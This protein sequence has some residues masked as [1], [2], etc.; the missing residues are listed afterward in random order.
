V[1]LLTRTMAILV[2]AF[3]LTAVAAFPP[4]A[5]GVPS[6]PEI[7]AKQAEGVAAQDQLDE[8]QAQLELRAEEYGAI[9]LELQGTR[10]EIA[11]TRA[12]LEKA[13]AELAR[14]LEQLEQRAA[15]IYRNGNVEI[16]D[17]LLGTTS[18]QDFLTRVDW[19]RRVNLSDAEIAAAVKTARQR[20]IETEEALERREQEQITLRD[21]AA[22]KKKEIEGAVAEQAAFLEGLNT[23]IAR[24]VEDERKRQEELAAERARQAAEAARRA[25]EAVGWSAG[26]PIA[27][28]VGSLGAGHPEALAAGLQYVGVPYV[29]GGA[30]PEGFDCSGLTQYAYA[31]VGISLPRTSREQFRAGQYIPADR[32]DLLVTGDLVFFGYGG[33]PNRIHHVGIY[34]GEGGFLHAPQTGSTV[35]VSSLL[36]RISSR[37]D[38]VGACRP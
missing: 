11:E 32:L 2:A 26:A 15:G 12:A 8:L 23:E 22:V 27:A 29:W 7:Q 30:S 5:A 1:S 3:A 9:T 37:A 38:F 18:F 16:L 21:Q 14:A 33:D 10:D 36:D 24:L 28:D 17:V 4:S 31:Q 6:T 19:L 20:V 13:D 35:Q 25:Q 34:A